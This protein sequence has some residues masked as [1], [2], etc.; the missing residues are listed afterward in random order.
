MQ[1]IIHIH[2]IQEIRNI[3]NRILIDGNYLRIIIISDILIISLFSK[4]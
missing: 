1:K 2:R 3:D 4:N